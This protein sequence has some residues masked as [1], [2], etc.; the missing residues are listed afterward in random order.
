M[1]LPLSSKSSHAHPLK[2]S[3]LKR[4]ARIVW[5]YREGKSLRQ[6][7]LRFKLS[8]GRIHQIIRRDAPEAMRRRGN[9]A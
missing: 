1:P 9:S 5:M 2:S 6:L 7:G 3:R 4:D 8:K